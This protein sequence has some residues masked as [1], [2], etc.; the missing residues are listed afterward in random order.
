[1]DE[2]ARRSFPVPV[3]LNRFTAPLLL[4][5]FGMCEISLRLLRRPTSLAQRISLADRQ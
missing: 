4:F 5:I 1:L 2:W 3:L